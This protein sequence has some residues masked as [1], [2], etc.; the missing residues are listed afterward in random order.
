LLP[1]FWCLFWIELQFL[2]RIPLQNRTG[3]DDSPK[4][5][6]PITRVRHHFP[7]CALNR[8]RDRLVMRYAQ[9]NRE[10]CG[11][12]ATAEVVLLDFFG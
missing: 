1:L 4:S 2:T 10:I 9:W 6:H 3:H 5:L 8:N 12:I 7:I 11:M